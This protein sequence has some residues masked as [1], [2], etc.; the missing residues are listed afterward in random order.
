MRKAAHRRTRTRTHTAVAALPPDD[1]SEPL[2]PGEVVTVDIAREQAD[3]DHVSRNTMPPTPA[4]SA[5]STCTSADDNS[6]TTR[7]ELAA[8]LDVLDH[9]RPTR[10]VQQSTHAR[11]TAWPGA[12]DTG[13]Y[14]VTG[15]GDASK[16]EPAD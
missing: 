6:F 9:Q 10:P 3:M 7:T 4:H 15:R 11:P 14:G 8:P 1:R 2:R 12:V 16:Y 5:S 13:S